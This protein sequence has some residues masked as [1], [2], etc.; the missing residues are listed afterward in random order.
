MDPLKAVNVGVAAHITAAAEGGPRYDSNLTE[1][2]RR[3]IKNGIW[4]CQ[5][6][7]KLIDS[8][9]ARYTVAILERWRDG[10]EQTARIELERQ[11]APTSDVTSFRR[12]LEKMPALLQ[13][14]ATDVR[15]DA[16]GLIRECVCKPGR[17]TVFNSS[18]PRFEYNTDDHPHLMN[19]MTMLEAFGFVV[20]V[21]PK[22]TPVY[23]MSESFVDLLLALMPA[24]EGA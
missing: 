11:G 9:V 13:E 1:L 22:N 7:S 3:D 8:D 2:Q 24:A 19:A 18:T 16:S 21:T 23:R 14:M 17:R 6:C 4:L 20:D 12:L 5:T 10:A 15:G